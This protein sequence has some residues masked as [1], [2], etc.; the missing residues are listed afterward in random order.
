[1]GKGIRVR[2]CGKK[3]QSHQNLLIGYGVS[4]I[5]FSLTQK[6]LFIFLSIS[7]IIFEKDKN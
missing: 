5:E 4:G 7:H 1:M 6:T 2:R 3:H